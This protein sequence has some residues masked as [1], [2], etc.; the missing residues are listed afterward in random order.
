MTHCTLPALKKIWEQDIKLKP[1]LQDFARCRYVE[2]RHDY[3]RFVALA[4]LAQRWALDFTDPASG[5]MT[6]QE[7]I[8]LDKRGPHARLHDWLVSTPVDQVDGEFIRQA[9]CNIASLEGVIDSLGFLA[10]GAEDQAARDKLPRELLSFLH[11]YDD[12]ICV[13]LSAKAVPTC[14]CRAERLLVEA[15]RM[16]GFHMDGVAGIKLP[17]D[18]RMADVNWM[19]RKFTHGRIWAGQCPEYQIR[20]KEKTQAMSRNASTA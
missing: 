7:L 6:T 19:D 20:A 5:F 14:A 9:G 4:V 16:L 2:A 3:E 1:W 17:L 12:A 18:P 15:E 13:L 10:I 11:A 8:V